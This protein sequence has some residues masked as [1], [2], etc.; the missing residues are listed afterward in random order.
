MMF[1]GDLV[2]LADIEQ[3]CEV[4]KVEHRLVLAVLAKESDI[5]AKVH[6]LEVI[7]DKTSVAALNALSEFI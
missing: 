1:A 4:V 6:I 5:F 7:R 2:Q 3:F